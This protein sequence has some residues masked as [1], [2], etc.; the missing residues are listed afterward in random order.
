MR[1]DPS[2]DRQM[3]GVD[4]DSVSGTAGVGVFKNHLGQGERSSEG[5][6]NGCADQSTMTK[7]R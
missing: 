2:R 5:S 4:R 3:R 6:R 1:G 7:L